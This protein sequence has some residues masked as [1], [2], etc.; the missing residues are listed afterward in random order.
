MST[1]SVTSS[2]DAARA[3]SR[4][5]GVGD[6]AVWTYRDAT[7]V[8]SVD[9]VIGTATFDILIAGIPRERAEPAIRALAAQAAARLTTSAASFRIP[10]TERFVGTWLVS[11]RTGTGREFPRSVFWIEPD[12]ALRMQSSGGLSGTLLLTGSSWRIE[13]R[14]DQEPIAG[15]YRLRGESLTFEGAQLEAQLTRVGCGAP[16]KTVKPPYD[17]TRDI[18]GFLNGK[19]LAALQVDEGT[20][21]PFNVD[22]AGL[23]E[24]DGSFNG[25]I[26]QAL[27]AIDD[28]GRSVFGLFPYAS[29]ASMPVTA[30]IECRSKATA[31]RRA[32]IGCRAESATA[33]S[34]SWKKATR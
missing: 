4:S 31:N 7:G 23:W 26:T 1:R 24:G 20:A 29:A 32:L 28:R 5:P 6:G 19:G 10:G 25:R 30:T 22:L 3:G 2:G 13:G 8:M 9:F 16:A 21:D 34:S 33:R 12:G 17:L 18:A 15:E 27:V 11:T 14:W